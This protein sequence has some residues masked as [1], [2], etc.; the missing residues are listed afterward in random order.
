[1]KSKPPIKLAS[2]E[3][4]IMKH[5]WGHGEVTIN[6]VLERTNANRKEPL[7]RATIQVQLR[8]LETKGWLRQRSEKRVLYYEALFERVE[9]ERAITE[10]VQSKV[11]EGSNVALLR[12]LF[13]AK[14]LTPEDVSFLKEIVDKH[15]EGGGSDV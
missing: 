15:E 6:D 12:C 5:I 1:M 2:A 13:E 14:E 8:R 4:E 9:A 7:K 10:E 3:F 11:F